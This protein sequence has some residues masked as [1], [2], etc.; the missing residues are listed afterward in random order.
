[1]LADTNESLRNGRR[2]LTVSAEY[3]RRIEGVVHDESAT[4]KTV[5]IEPAEVMPINNAI[6]NL[7]TDRKKEVYKVLKDL[8][9]QIRPYADELTIIESVLIELDLIRAKSRVGALMDAEKPQL[10]HINHK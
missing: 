2:V 10:V 4:G 8:C 1:M 7:Y 6:F 9:A 3:K 5:Y